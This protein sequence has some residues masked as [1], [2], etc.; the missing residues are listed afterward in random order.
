MFHCVNINVLHSVLFMIEQAHRF[1]DNGGLTVMNVD[2]SAKINHYKCTKNL[3]FS[4]RVG[5]IAH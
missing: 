1:L 3:E 2:C 5:T 4:T